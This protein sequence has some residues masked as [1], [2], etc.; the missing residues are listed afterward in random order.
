MG[1]DITSEASGALFKWIE[2]ARMTIVTKKVGRE[3]AKMLKWWAAIIDVENNGE[4]DRMV[5]V[6]IGAK[7]DWKRGEMRCVQRAG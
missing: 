3:D 7:D 4:V 1:S 6:N 5:A 2:R